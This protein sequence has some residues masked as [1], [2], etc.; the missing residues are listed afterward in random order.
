ML[1][2]GSACLFNQL[3]VCA[4]I[5]AI[6]VGTG[7]ESVSNVAESVPFPASRMLIHACFFDLASHCEFLAY[8]RHFQHLLLNVF[9]HHIRGGV[10]RANQTKKAVL[11][12]RLL[13]QRT[14]NHR[15]SRIQS[16]ADDLAQEV[17]SLHPSVQ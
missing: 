13:G 15:L 5:G 7:R 11:A 12:F 4:L 2:L 8:V 14:I 3:P 9:S 16:Q 17:V 10:E 1:L 6:W